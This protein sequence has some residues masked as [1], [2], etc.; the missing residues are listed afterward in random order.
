MLKANAGFVRFTPPADR[1]VVFQ[2]GVSTATAPS[3]SPALPNPFTAFQCSVDSDGGII[4]DTVVYIS[5][6]NNVEIQVAYKITNAENGLPVADSLVT[7]GPFKM[8][9]F[10][11]A[12]AL[13]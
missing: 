11:L 9:A 2:V 13:R 3:I 1:V 6:R 12:G 8:L 10:S 7:I 5:N 4:Y